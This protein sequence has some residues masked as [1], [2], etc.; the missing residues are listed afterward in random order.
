VILTD[1]LLLMLARGVAVGGIALLSIAVPVFAAY[2]VDGV[3]NLIRH[4][5]ARL[6]IW[7]A[8]ISIGLA[9]LGSGAWWWGTTNDMAG[10][11]TSASDMAL[12]QIFLVVT[13]P[14]ALGASV[15]RVVRSRKKASNA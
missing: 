8:A 1:T 9:A 4:K 12:S 6:L 2:L 7:A 15:I 14:F 5:G 3:V 13:V 11:D 10:L